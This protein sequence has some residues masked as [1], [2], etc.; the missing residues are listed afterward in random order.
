MYEAL[1]REIAYKSKCEACFIMEFKPAT[2]ELVSPIDSQVSIKADSKSI[3]S[4]VI[5]GLGYTTIND[6][7]KF[8][9]SQNKYI[10][11]VIKLK[12]FNAMFVSLVTQLDSYS[13]YTNNTQDYVKYVI[14]LFNHHG[15]SKF[16][17]N[18]GLQLIG[19]DQNCYCNFEIESS[20]IRQKTFAD[21][22]SY[23]IQN[24]DYQQRV[25]RK[26]MQDRRLI[27]LI[28]NVL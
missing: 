3:F 13:K 27:S 7:S 26:Q 23:F 19:D 9:I 21:F 1:Q 22:F 10:G 20:L 15:S 5:F 8:R 2:L 28:E 11:E 17:E 24:I 16:K 6:S 14:C 25:V 4:D 18:Q 12:I